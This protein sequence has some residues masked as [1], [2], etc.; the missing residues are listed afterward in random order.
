MYADFVDGG[1]GAL[2]RCLLSVDA[3]DD[4]AAI[5]REDPVTDG[6]LAFFWL[7]GP[8]RLVCRP[9]DHLEIVVRPVEEEAGGDHVA[10]RGIQVRDEVADR[11][12]DRPLVAVH[13]AIGV[14]GTMKGGHRLDR[15]VGNR[16]SRD[17][18]EL[19]QR[20]VVVEDGY[21]GCREFA[22][23]GKVL[24]LAG[25]LR[26]VRSETTGTDSEDE[27]DRRAGEQGTQTAV[28]PPLAFRLALRGDATVGEEVALE[29]VEIDRVVGGPLERC[30]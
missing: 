9:V 23:T 8:Q 14:P 19:A 5:G 30:G 1:A 24:R 17:G 22:R 13:H 20:W 21:S 12:I 29:G 10:S 7:E 26:L 15:W 16:C 25:N 6:Q 4:A 3:E 27:K 28:R 11:S 18:Q 2:R